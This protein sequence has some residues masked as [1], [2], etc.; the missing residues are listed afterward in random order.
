MDP[1]VQWACGGVWGKGISELGEKAG[2]SVNGFQR[3]RLIESYILLRGNRETLKTRLCK[4]CKTVVWSH[5]GWEMPLR[6]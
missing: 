1:L 4:V 3:E 6:K 2:S 5:D